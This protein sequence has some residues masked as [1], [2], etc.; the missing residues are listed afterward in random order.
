MMPARKREAPASE[1]PPVNVTAVTVAAEPQLPDTFDLPAVVEPNEIVSVSAEVAGQI[2]W[3]GPREGA[4]VRTG[5]PLLRL[6]TDL[7]QAEH[8]RVQAQAQYDQSEFERQ[9][10]LVQ[11]GAAPSRD[12]DE[13]AM[14]L[15]VS[16]AQLEEVRARLART[17]IT[18]PSS[19][20]LNDLP[21]EQGE[22]VQTGTR[23]ADIVDTSVVKVVVDVPERDIAFFS[24]GQK[25]EILTD[26]AAQPA[27]LEGA[28]TFISELADPKTRSTRME[29]TLPNEEGRLRSGQ[30]VRVRMTRRVL[31]DVV[32]IPL[33]A[34]IPMEETKAVYVVESS[35]AQ[36]REVELGII[37]GDRVQVTRG[38]E[39]G[40]QLIVSG[41]RLVAPDQ[42]VN[43]VP[44][45]GSEDRQLP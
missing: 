24:V 17:Q 20:V 31:Q 40:D 9:K 23:V 21:V 5:D 4:S 27:V 28:I 36:R 15:A 25:V 6:N 37:R 45:N 30:I 43:V 7:L 42:A 3:T 22:Y 18:A 16:K 2:E 35:K 41:H 33:L 44:I 19:G 34:V 11:G 39:P 8:D 12:L 14:K 32:M 29:I 38:L 26:A 1:V 10:G 13:A